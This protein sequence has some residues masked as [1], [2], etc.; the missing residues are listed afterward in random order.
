MSPENEDPQFWDERYR[1][2]QMPWHLEG[3]PAPLQKWLDETPPGSVLIPGCGAGQGVSAFAEAGWDVTGIEFSR[4]ALQHARKRL[5]NLADR[6]LLADFFQHD[7]AG[8]HFTVVYERTFL[9]ALPL[10]RRPDY[11]DRIHSLLEPEGQLI[12]AFFYGYDEDPPPNPIAPGDEVELFGSHFILEEDGSI[13]NSLA[14]FEGR[15]RWQRWR[16]KTNPAG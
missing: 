3:V 12:G 14:L 10:A 4:E 16:K 11:T 2:N 5:G 8:K 1:A 13:G 7:F 6:I 9:C 15:E